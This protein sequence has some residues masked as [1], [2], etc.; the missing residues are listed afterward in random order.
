ML[1]KQQVTE[2][3]YETVLQHLNDMIKA[4]LPEP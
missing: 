3:V 2:D 1:G 4:K